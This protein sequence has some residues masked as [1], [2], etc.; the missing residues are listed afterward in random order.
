MAVAT[1]AVDA[2]ARCHQ[3]PPRISHLGVSERVRLKCAPSDQDT[4]GEPSPTAESWGADAAGRDVP[5]P[6]THKV[7]LPGCVPTHRSQSLKIRSA[8][9]QRRQPRLGFDGDRRLLARAR[10]IVQRGHRA[11]HPGSFNATLD[12]LMMR[13][14]VSPGT[15]VKRTHT[16]LPIADRRSANRSVGDKSRPVTER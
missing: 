15:S 10:S 6:L 16:G 3:P 8:A 9:S 2:I 13:S 11:F 12:G 14:S 1:C 5:I 7:E 4:V